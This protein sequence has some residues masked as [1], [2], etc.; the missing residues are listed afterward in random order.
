M[1]VSQN[2]SIAELRPVRVSLPA[3]MRLNEVGWLVCD[4]E[5]DRGRDSDHVGRETAKLLRRNVGIG[6]SCHRF[7]EF[8]DLGT[9][10][11]DPCAFFVQVGAHGLV[12]CQSKT[13]GSVVYPQCSLDGA[14]KRVFRIDY[15]GDL[16]AVAAVLLDT[17][18]DLD[19]IDSSSLA[20]GIQHTAP[21]LVKENK[22]K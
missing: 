9:R 15:P 12:V 21:L 7:E 20:N 14:E 4:L 13:Y 8:R 22:I 17:P 6:G 1:A 3:E 16:L 19:G 11:P 2:R 5:K 10:D 18:S